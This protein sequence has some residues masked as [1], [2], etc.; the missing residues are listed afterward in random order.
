[1]VISDDMVIHDF[2][3]RHLEKEGYSIISANKGKLGLEMAREHLPDIITLDV[4]MED[5]EGWD[6][7][8][9]LKSDDVLSDIP[10]IMLTISEDKQKQVVFE[11]FITKM[12]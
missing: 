12:E 3:R 11:N 1:M 6:V 10:V 8:R 7:N 4:Y 2:L 5:I 9:I